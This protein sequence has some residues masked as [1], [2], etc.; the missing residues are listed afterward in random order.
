MR[1]RSCAPICVKTRDR[2]PQNRQ[3][4]FVTRGPRRSPRGET[5]MT[6]GEDGTARQIAALPPAAE[7]RAAS[8]RACLALARKLLKRSFHSLRELGDEALQPV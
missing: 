5:R 4:T 8:N 6:C 3:T 7:I 2:V 1:S